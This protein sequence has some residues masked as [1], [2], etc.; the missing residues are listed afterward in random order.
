MATASKHLEL[1]ADKVNWATLR[2][3]DVLAASKMTKEHF[4]CVATLS[5]SLLQEERN[6]PTVHTSDE[7]DSDTYKLMEESGYDFSKPPSLGYVIDATPDRPNG[8][9][10]MVQKQMTKL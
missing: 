5:K 7:F 6:L 1:V 3:N 8:A 9:Q 4:P 10:K 2:E